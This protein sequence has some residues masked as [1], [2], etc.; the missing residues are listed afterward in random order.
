MRYCR[1]SAAVVWWGRIAGMGLS[2]WR[3]KRHMKDPVRGVFRVTGCYDKRMY[4]DPPGARI[5]GVIIAPGVPATVAEHRFDSR[6]RWTNAKELPVLV[7]RSDPTRFAILWDEVPATS[8]ADQERHHAQEEADR[9]NSGQ[10]TGSAP[11]AG[12]AMQLWPEVADAVRAALGQA[13]NAANVTVTVQQQ[14]VI[15]APGRPAPGMPGGGLT[16]D[17]VAQMLAD[18]GQGAGRRGRDR[19]TRDRDSTGNAR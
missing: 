9:I 6:G 16:P 2:D 12:Q 5:T 14:E 1:L 13:V 19:R 4:S 8:W 7:D 10:P 15:G 17:Q 18:G 3:A 11:A